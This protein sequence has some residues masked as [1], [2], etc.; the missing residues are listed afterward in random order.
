MNALKT[1]KR[2]T[3][4][5]IYRRPTTAKLITQIRSIRIELDN[6]FMLSI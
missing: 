1:R 6:V 3:N 5:T 4:P 2:K